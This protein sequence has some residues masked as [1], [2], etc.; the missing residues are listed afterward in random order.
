MTP[1]QQAGAI[2]RQ[3]AVKAAANPAPTPKPAPKP[4]PKPKEPP[5]THEQKVEK[6]L[7]EIRDSNKSINTAVWILATIALLAE[8]AGFITFLHLAKS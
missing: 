6:V 5:L 3:N 2:K 4:P 8:L 1:E 7:L